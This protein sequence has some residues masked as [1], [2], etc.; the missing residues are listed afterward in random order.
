MIGQENHEVLETGYFV[1]Q[2]MKKWS[3]VSV[4]FINKPDTPI[5][6]FSTTDDFYVLGD[7]FGTGVWYQA[8]SSEDTA[9]F[10]LW[11][12]SIVPVEWKLQFYD[13]GLYFDRMFITNDTTEEEILAGFNIPFDISKY[14]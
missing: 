7:F 13:S 6:Q 1:E 2:L 9:R 14:E 12:R 4:V 8:F 10:A 11:Y 5:L 3:G